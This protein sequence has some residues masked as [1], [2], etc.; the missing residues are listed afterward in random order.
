MGLLL[1]ILLSFLSHLNMMV[2]ILAFSSCFNH[3]YSFLELKVVSG[4]HM[5]FFLRK[6]HRFE[7]NGTSN[8]EQRLWAPESLSQIGTPMKASVR[9][10]MEKLCI[11][12]GGRDKRH[13]QQETS[14]TKVLEFSLDLRSL[15]LFQ[16]LKITNQV[17]TI[18]YISGHGLCVSWS[19]NIT[20]F[21]PA[22]NQSG[23]KRKC[24]KWQAFCISLYKY[25]NKWQPHK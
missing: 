7:T 24:Y 2:L 10:L 4:N 6:G 15:V 23:Q 22:M 5:D 20:C 1:L 25:T 9:G 14:H 19:H 12:T 13:S 17:G 21:I 16:H 11:G 8:E 3:Y 18:H